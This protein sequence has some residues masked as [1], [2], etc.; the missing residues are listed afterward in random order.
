M[1]TYRTKNTRTISSINT[2]QSIT[3]QVVLSGS[4]P[5]VLCPGGIFLLEMLQVDDSGAGVSLVDGNSVTIASGVKSFSQDYSPLRCDGGITITGTVVLAKG[6]IV[7][8]CL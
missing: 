4:S 6:F 8:G 7:E 5:S 2:S 3:G 1:A